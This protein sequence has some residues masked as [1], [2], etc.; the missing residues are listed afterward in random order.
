MSRLACF[1]VQPT[2]PANSASVQ[3][4]SS[5]MSRMV[6]PGGGSGH[7]GR[8]W[9]GFS[10][11]GTGQSVTGPTSLHATGERLRVGDA[12][13]FDLLQ[14]RGLGKRTAGIPLFSVRVAEEVSVKMSMSRLSMSLRLFSALR[15]F[16]AFIVLSSFSA[17]RKTSRSFIL[18][19]FRAC[20]HKRGKASSRP[21]A[22]AKKAIIPGSGDKRDET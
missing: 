9:S 11:I 12:A 7:F 18:P 14:E 10:V 1:A 17:R 22:D 8:N 16:P 4:F 5:R 3:L 21:R 2:R 15:R 20:R 13:A 19:W 6:S